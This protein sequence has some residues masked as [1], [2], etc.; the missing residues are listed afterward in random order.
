MHKIQS[1]IP[2]FLQGANHLTCSPLTNE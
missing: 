2:N 1:W